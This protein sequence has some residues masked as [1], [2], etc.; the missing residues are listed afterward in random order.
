MQA[1]PQHLTHEHGSDT[2]SWKTKINF[3]IGVVGKS[4]VYGVAGKFEYF[5]LT[6][7]GMK[8]S[9]LTVL[10][11]CGRLWDGVND[12]LMGS[13]ID[14]TRSRWGKFRPWLALGSVLNAFVLIGMFTNPAPLRADS[15]LRYA[16]FAMFFVLWDMTFTMGDVSYYAMIPALSRNPQQ[17]DQLAIIPRVFAGVL[18]VATAFILDIVLL[19][20]K[21]SEMRGFFV[22]ASLAG[23]VAMATGL[24]AAVTLKEAGESPAPVAE[25]VSP[26]RVLRVI[27]GNKQCLA[28]IGV[29]IFFNLAANATNGASQYYFKFVV[30]DTRQYGFWGIALGAANGVGLFL[31]PA[32]CKRFGRKRVFAAA[33]ALPPV[34]CAFMAVASRAPVQ[35]FI[36][37]LLGACVSAVGYG[38]M[39]AMQSVMLADSVDYGEFTTGQRSEGVIF[40]TLT[41]LSRIASALGDASR[42]GVFSYTSFGGEHAT[43]ATPAARQ[44]IA[45]LMYILPPLSMIV[46]VLIYRF[47][48]RLTP[49]R[50]TQIR[51]ELAERA[52]AGSE[53]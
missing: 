26:F 38:F 25:R 39:S 10:L 28:T 5:L 50:M 37:L 46:S 15:P 21:G 45:F 2:L 32:L 49:E 35:T 8:K 22:Y 30:G 31:Y 17:R 53:Q 13:V 34:G 48:Y 20:G 29:M 3:G 4:L 6:L 9:F 16:W 33:F 42:M 7:L 27:A 51:A 40:S 41:M 44:G 1:N 19:L 23:A 52:A 11:V 36:P 12:L 24:Y 47:S 14:S 43:A 18:G